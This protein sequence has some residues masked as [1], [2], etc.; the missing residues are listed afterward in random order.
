MNF[1][2]YSAEDAKLAVQKFKACQETEAKN[3]YEKVVTEI[4]RCAS[5]GHQTIS[6]SISKKEYGSSISAKLSSKGFDCSFRSFTDFRGE[7]YNE[8]SVSF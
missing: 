6:I 5:M 8:M 3:E 2:T 4:H 7:E 1:E